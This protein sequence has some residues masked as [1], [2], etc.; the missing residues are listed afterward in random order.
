MSDKA[1]KYN[2]KARLDDLPRRLYKQAIKELPRLIG[3]DVSQFYRIINYDLES[4]S[5][6]N[7]DQLQI[8]ASYLE[9]TVD[10]LLNKQVLDAAESS[11]H[12]K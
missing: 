1:Y 8:I 10:D 9:C 3:V 7:S 4:R 2:I 11:A 12:Q 6:I 5:A